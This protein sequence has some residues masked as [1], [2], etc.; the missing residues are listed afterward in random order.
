MEL[1]EATNSATFTLSLTS[2]SIKQGNDETLRSWLSC[3]E[4]RGR[5]TS[6]DSA[7][8]KEIV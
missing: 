7:H 1:S 3:T 4:N 6:V 5:T 8:Q 2:S